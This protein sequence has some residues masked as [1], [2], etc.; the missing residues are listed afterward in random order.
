MSPEFPNDE[1][2][3]QTWKTCQVHQPNEYAA[4]ASRI[5]PGSMKKRKGRNKKDENRDEIVPRETR[6]FVAAPADAPGVVERPVE[7]G[8]DLDDAGVEDLRLVDDLGVDLGVHRPQVE[9]PQEPAVVDPDHASDGGQLPT[10]RA[11]NSQFAPRLSTRRPNG[12]FVVSPPL[13]YGEAMT[14]RA[15]ESWIAYSIRPRWSTS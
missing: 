9:A 3:P 6:K 13:A 15:L 11:R 8:R 4:T 10:C 5:R 12:M 7:V 14:M 1:R 2:W